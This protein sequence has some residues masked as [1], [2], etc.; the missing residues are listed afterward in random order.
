ML[1]LGSL[2]DGIGGW[3]LAAIHNDVKPIWSSEIEKFPLAVTR[4]R[5]PDTIQLGD[6]TK[7]DGAKI[8]PVD[9]I[10][11]GS[12]CQDLSIAGKQEGLSGKRSGLFYRAINL[13][14]QMRVATGEYPKF[15]VWENVPGAF[16]SNKGMD[17]KAV[18]EEITES[19][20]PVPRS[21]KWSTAGMVRSGKC[22]IAWRVLDAQYWGVPQRRKRV[23]L[24]ADFRTEGRCTDKILFEP[25]GL[26]GNTSEGGAKREKATDR[27]RE[28][29][30]NTSVRPVNLQVA[31]RYKAL[32]EGTGFGI[33]ENGEPAYTLQ[34]EH[35][36]GVAVYE[37]HA[38]DSR[39]TKCDNVSPTIRGRCGTG[40]NNLPLVFEPGV[41]TRDGGH[42]YQDGKAP[43]LRSNPGDNFPTVFAI[44]GTGSRPSH[45]GIGYSDDGKS[46]T[47]NTVERHAVAVD[48]YNGN[49]TGD[50][51]C[52]VTTASNI[53]NG[54]SPKV[55][56]G[57]GRDAFNQG[58][59]AKFDM[60]ISENIQPSMVAKG[61][62]AVFC[63]GHD[64]RSASFKEN[65]TDPLVSS[66]Y[67][68]PPIINTLEKSIRRLTPLECERLQGLPDNFTLI[69]NRTC[70]D[71]ARYKALG[72]GMAQPCADYVIQQIKEN[73][74]E[75]LNGKV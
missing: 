50:K 37:N 67:K 42:I 22:D 57:I 13:V 12:P 23:F 1:T 24:V 4:E 26:P 18:L 28:S 5:F 35:S 66:D 39:I 59:N 63:M 2:F 70:S 71:S 36:H 15:F 55:A 49:I 7:I 34:A 20:I 38:S 52:S 31:T 51:T 44:E 16:S 60:S 53:S 46:F 43:T 17:F 47:L 9:I 72:N 3:Q 21:G 6:I 64:E 48:V 58:K 65:K 14:R 30:E 68:Q 11:A 45:H 41:A 10:C 40:G 25:K 56:Y 8:E 62:G 33:G 75:G 29:V 73:F 61:A 74:M 27:T 69:D 54:T 32:G 19:E